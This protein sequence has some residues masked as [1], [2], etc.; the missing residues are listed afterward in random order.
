MPGRRMPAIVVGRGETGLGTLR[1]LVLA[2]IPAYVACPK[3]DLVTHSRWYRPVPGPGWDGSTDAGTAERLRAL[4]LPGAVLV[5]GRD[6]AALWLADLPHGDLVKRFAVSSSPRASLEI[7]QDKARFG[8]YLATTAVP[9]P[10][11][12]TIASAA[13]IAAIPF[14][15]LDRVF[16]KPADSQRFNQAIGAKGIWAKTRAEFEA[17]WSRLD[18]QGFALIAQE[19]VPGRASDH[20]FID[21]F[22]DAGGALTGLF[23]RRRWR[24]YPADFGNSSYCESVPLAQLGAAV[25]HLEALLADLRYRGIFSAEFKRDARSGELRIL[26]INTRAW[27]YVEFAAR[28][29]VNVCAMAYED[30]QG[31]PVTRPARAPV[32]GAGCV[33]LDGDLKAVLAAGVHQ[34]R[35]RAARQWLHAHCHVF[36]WD[37]PRPAW[38]LLWARLRLQANRWRRPAREPLAARE[39]LPSERRNSTA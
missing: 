28:C 39:P 15:E 27:W 24:I 10:R 31:L 7:L 11:T 16:I 6:D 30:A 13:D 8:R 9:H 34:S 36:R 32:T 1:S 14:D 18:S 38:S 21:G 20:Y 26:E 4:P 22:R 25:G 17:I 33:N 29:G 23:A 3:D 5:P 35:W 2:G 12:F 19:Y 37:D